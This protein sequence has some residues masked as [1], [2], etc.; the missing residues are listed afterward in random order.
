MASITFEEIDHLNFVSTKTSFNPNHMK[1]NN[2]LA[3]LTICTALFCPLAGRADSVINATN[4][5]NWGDPTIW[6]SGTV[7][8]TNVYANIPSGIDVT[9]TT[10]AYVEYLTGL[11]TV[12]MAA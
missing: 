4:S 8:G 7:P 11:G 1:I 2:Y 12:T 3:A 5:G 10:N 6:D 9:V